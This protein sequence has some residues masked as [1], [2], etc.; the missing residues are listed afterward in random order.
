MALPKW[1]VNYLN[2]QA[3]GWNVPKDVV[4]RLLEAA[5]K[6]LEKEEELR[7]KEDG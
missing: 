3:E 1:E 5:Q 6:Q 2:V 7:D 4:T